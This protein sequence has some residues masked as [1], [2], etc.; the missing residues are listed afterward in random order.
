MADSSKRGQA[1]TVFAILFALLAVSNFLKPI[2]FSADQGFVFFGQ[3]L[4]GFWNAILG[5]LFGV[6][7]LVYAYGIW[8]MKRFAM[9]MGHAYATYV[10]LNLIIFSMSNPSPQTTGETAFIVVYAIVAIGVSAGSAAILT[11]RKDELS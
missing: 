10:I 4:T 8:N 9:A 11:K 3:R 5:P 6:F 2:Q 7:L 1:L